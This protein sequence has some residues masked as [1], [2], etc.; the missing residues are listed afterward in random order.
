M[1][2]TPGAADS[3]GKGTEAPHNKSGVPEAEAAVDL[4][5]KYDPRFSTL[6]WKEKW[7]SQGQCRGSTG[8]VQSSDYAGIIFLRPVHSNST[9]D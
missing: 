7:A 4:Q 3:A 6:K 2:A 1:S 5:G 8:P 9:S